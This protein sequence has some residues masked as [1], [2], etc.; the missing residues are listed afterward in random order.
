M[1]EYA[2]LARGRAVNWA[3]TS[4]EAK[5]EQNFSYA[6]QLGLVAPLLTSRTL[7]DWGVEP[8]SQQVAFVARLRALLHVRAMTANAPG[9]QQELRNGLEYVALFLEQAPGRV[10]FRKPLSLGDYEYNA[11]S[12]GLLFTF[13]RERGSRKAGASHGATLKAKTIAGLVSTVTTFLSKIAKTDLLRAEDL[14]ELRAAKKQARTLDGPAGERR[15]EDPLRAVHLKVALG[16]GGLERQTPYGVVRAAALLF[17]H[18]ILGR[19]TT[20]GL[21]DA[22]VTLDAARHFTAA[23][24]DWEA[25]AAMDPPALVGWV[26]PAK[27]PTQTKPRYPMLVQRRHASA[28]FGSD[29]LC[30]YDAMAAAWA[31]LGAP[32]TAQ[33]RASTLFFRVPPRGACRWGV[34]Q[35]GGDS[36]DWPPLTDAVLA[37]WV[38]EAAV[39]AGVDPAHRGARALR[40]G[41]ATDMYDI[42]GP[43]GERYIRERGRWGSDVAQIYQRVSAAAHGAISREMGDSTG[44]DLQSMM[45]GWS[46]LAVSHGRCPH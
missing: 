32:L 7:D 40:M 2:P 21:K 24:I 10:M 37:Q 22:H 8:S 19:G 4:E 14:A 29:P 31:I 27:D 45:A 46:Q 1:G 35:I 9:Y 43:A 13:V 28:A 16:P 18:N 42:Y 39:A 11:G 41:G 12:A 23:C 17:G 6:V 5:A 15:L 30:T 26:H 3:P 44:A 25:A 38:K 33:Q 34:E 36:A 20:I